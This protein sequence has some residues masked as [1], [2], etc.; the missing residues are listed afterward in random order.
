MK[1]IDKMK[2]IFIGFIVAILI[3]SIIGVASDNNT[4]DY[5]KVSITTKSLGYDK[6]FGESRILINMTINALGR[7]AYREYYYL[8][9]GNGN[10]KDHSSRT[11]YDQ[12][13]T[14]NKLSFEI[15]RPKVGSQKR[16][17]LI[18]SV[19]VLDNNIVFQKW[20][21]V[22]KNDKWTA[23][24]LNNMTELIRVPI[25]NTDNN[26]DNKITN[27]SNNTNGTT[28]PT[29]KQTINNITND[30]ISEPIMKRSYLFMITAIVLIGL[31]V[32]IIHRN[33]RD[34]DK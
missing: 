31:M 4:Q 3:I 21:N 14:A 1:K 20:S 7:L 2:K 30:T 5:V 32:T 27:V 19:V 23:D 25:N 33:R 18:K 24:K 6:N 13:I 11:F 16:Y 29:V 12:N 34:K 9:D 15:L 28:T 26:I 22:D 17:N 10:P 8:I